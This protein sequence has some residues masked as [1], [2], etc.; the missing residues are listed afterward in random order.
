MPFGCNFFSFLTF[1][2]SSN[3]INVVPEMVNW[4]FAVKEKWFHIQVKLKSIFF[5]FLRGNQR[6]NLQLSI[7]KK[8]TEHKKILW[9]AISATK[10]T[11]K[12]DI[13]LLKKWV[14]DAFNGES[15]KSMR[16]KFHF[17]N[18]RLRIFEHNHLRNYNINHYFLKQCY[19]QLLDTLLTISYHNLNILQY[20]ITISTYTI[21]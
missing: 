17:V 14:W 12:W 6:E 20:L 3:E 18:W 13:M 4:N 9:A 21:Q 19:Y 11:W 7:K 15:G 16:V 10:R 8:T 2:F 5:Y 1:Y